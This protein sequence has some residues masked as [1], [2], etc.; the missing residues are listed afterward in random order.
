MDFLAAQ[1]SARRTTRLLLALFGAFVLAA[2]AAYAWL[3]SIMATKIALATGSSWTAGASGLAVALV[4]MMVAR[5]WRTYRR[6]AE[7]A[8]ILAE[9]GAQLVPLRP[10]DRRLRQFRN[11]A[12][13]VAVAASL[14][15]PDLWLLPGQGGINALAAG[16]HE[17]H[18]AILVTDEA[19]HRLGRDELQAVI[20]H[21]VAHIA[22]GDTRTNTLMAA[23]VAGASA[24][25]VP[26]V[27][28]GTLLLRGLVSALQGM[29]GDTEAGLNV[30]SSL[31]ILLGVLGP[32]LPL[33]FVSVIYSDAPGLSTVWV[34]LQGLI[35]LAGIGLAGLILGSLLTAS[36][37]RH[38]EHHADALAVQLTR[39]PEALASA[40]R[41]VSRQ[42][43]GG[44]VV[45]PERTRLDHFFFARPSVDPPAFFGME[46]HPGLAER[47][48]Q[49]GPASPGKRRRR[50]P[51]RREN[52]ARPGSGAASLQT[53]LALLPDALLEAVHEIETAQAAVLAVTA[54]LGRTPAESVRQSVG[55]KAEEVLGLAEALREGVDLL[56]AIE[57][58]LPALHRLAEDEQARFRVEVQALVRADDETTFDEFA[59][60]QM[61]RWGLAA[62]PTGTVLSA[63][64]ARQSEVVFAAL[65]AVGAARAAEQSEAVQAGRRALAASLRVPEPSGVIHASSYADL[66]RALSSL[67]RGTPV[68]RH[69]VLDA[70][71]AVVRADRVTKPHE[72]MLMRATAL[73]LGVAHIAEPSREAPTS[74]SPVVRRHASPAHA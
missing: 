18:R 15:V 57:V 13:E 31:V 43:M 45:S 38:R 67:R 10:R 22:S 63:E 48:K 28:L 72:Q 27:W 51:A 29:D 44:H 21:E 3:L 47:A 56:P 9:A 71:Y 73:A 36:L 19:L 2:G 68:Q 39:Y 32:M 26:F 6:L 7:P 52:A 61:L 40:I 54:F 55:A 46:A 23:L 4:G 34:L 24:G 70:A 59:I 35:P 58:A 74:A 50:P 49:I 41:A 42:P 8:R 25:L 5:A 37:S 64:I 11:V 33:L 30:G 53:P 69:A 60:L 16:V 12:E 1:K 17:G 66:D 20:A 62:P 65:A 14:P